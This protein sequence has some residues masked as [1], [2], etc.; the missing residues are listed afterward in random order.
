MAL[1]GEQPSELASPQNAWALLEP[2]DGT[3]ENAILER[4]AVYRFQAR[5]SE[6]WR[7]GRA[8][9]AGDA[10]HLM[11]PFAGEGMCAGVRDAIALGWRLDLVLR[12]IADDALLDS[13]GTER[14]EHV[15]HYIDFSM[16]LGRI[17]CITD[18]DEAAERDAR[19]IAQMESYDGTP[20]NTDIGILGPGLGV[21]SDRHVG[22]LA[23]QDTVRMGARHGRFDDVVGR[24]WILIGLP[25]NPWDALTPEQR[26]ALQRLDATAVWVGPDGSDAPVVDVD[27]VFAKWLGD[28]E[29][30]YIVLRPDFYVAA[31]AN[32]AEHLRRSVDT[33]V[34][35][36]HLTKT[37]TAA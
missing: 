8:L 21:A 9:I 34:A 10:A 14:K 30:T 35:R 23:H 22:E 33:L 26:E 1:P 37:G 5:W 18:P 7:K 11:P 28:I 20:V 19:M 24:G 2:W 13:Y 12:G 17:I 36:L 16:E 4:S 15:K 25:D 29:A 6:E 27:G 3:P 31:T 32:D